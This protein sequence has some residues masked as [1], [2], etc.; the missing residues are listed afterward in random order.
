V[1]YLTDLLDAVEAAVSVDPQR[2]YFT[3]HSNGGFMSH[4]MACEHAD[5]IAAIASLAGA[6]FDDPADC[7]ATEPVNV[8]QIHGTAD[9][10]IQFGGDCIGASCYPSAQDTVRQWYDRNGCTGAPARGPA[11]DLDV[12]NAGDETRTFFAETCDPGGAVSLW[13]LDGSGHSPLLTTDFAASVV[14]YLL[15]HP[16]P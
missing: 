6:A 4:R 7:A 1:G 8:L 15:D 11:L 12:F 9:T 5:R 13:V 2:V 14:R 16:K 10:V 3:G